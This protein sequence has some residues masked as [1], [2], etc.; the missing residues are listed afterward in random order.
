[1]IFS[2]KDIKL[3]TSL[4]LLQHPP[5]YKFTI[6]NSGFSK[7][8]NL[9]F[10]QENG[11]ILPFNIESKNIH[12]IDF[13]NDGNKDIIY[14]DSFPYQTTL[15]FVNK[16]NNFF[17]IWTG[18]GGLVEIKQEKETIIY[19]LNHPIGCYNNIQLIEIMVNNDNYVTENLIAY[20]VDP[21]IKNLATVFKQKKLSGILRI[22]PILDN[23]IKI[24]PCTGESITGNQVRTIKN[25]TVTIIK[26]QDNWFLVLYKENDIS[27]ISWIQI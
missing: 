3:E 22:Q 15:L 17:E 9:K 21:K 4:R 2:Q 18:A 13:N 16:N 25:E 8:T 10:Y 7:I 12:F 19:V 26:K 14:Q 23:K 5:E 11:T 6:D 24:D 1:M 27:I 20:H